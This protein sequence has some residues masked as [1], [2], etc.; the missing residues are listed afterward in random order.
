MRTNN[1]TYA[2]LDLGFNITMWNDG[3]LS[4]ERKAKLSEMYIPNAGEII[5]F[6]WYFWMWS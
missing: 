4:E 1:R 6:G 5:F 2:I 3:S